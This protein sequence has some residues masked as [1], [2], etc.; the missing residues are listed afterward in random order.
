M[1]ALAVMPVAFVVGARNGQLSGVAFA[2][3]LAYPLVTLPS[4]RF[5]FRRLSIQPAAYLGALVRPAVGAAMTGAAILAGRGLVASN[6]NAVVRLAVAT[7]AAGLGYGAFLWWQRERVA[8]IMRV[9]R[10]RA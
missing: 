6:P 4:Y 2:W 3:V 5:L 7:V 9:A 8:M 10:G 1:L